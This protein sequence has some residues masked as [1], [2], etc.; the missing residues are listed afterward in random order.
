[1]SDR[2]TIVRRL[3]TLLAACLL[4]GAVSAVAAQADPFGELHQFGEAELKGTEVPEKA[5]GVDAETGDVYAVVESSAGKFTLS[6]FVPGGGTYKAAASVTFQPEAEKYKESEEIGG[7]EVEGV[8]IDSKMHRA[9]V[10]VNEARE[11]ESEVEVSLDPERP[12]AAAIY[13]FSTVASGST[14]VP[15]VGEGGKLVSSIALQPLSNARGIS[16]VEPGGIAVDPT[17]DQIVLAANIDRNLKHEEEERTSVIQRISPTGTL[18]ARYLAPRTEAANPNCG[19][20]GSPVVS[21]TGAVYVLGEG[22][23]ILE[24]PNPSTTKVAPETV[25]VKPVVK[26]KFNFA[27]EFEEE[28]RIGKNTELFEEKLL[29]VEEEHAGSAL[30]ISPEGDLWAYAR[31]KYQL[32]GKAEEFSYGGAVEFNSEFDEIGWTGGQS[33]AT[34]AGKCVVDD[35]KELPAIAAG[36]GG[37]LFALDRSPAN[38]GQGESESPHIIEFGTGGGGCPHGQGTLEASTGGQSLPEGATVPEGE[39]VT[40]TTPLLQA[41]A[42][43]TEWEFEPGVKPIVVDKRE[44]EQTQIEHKFSV[45]GDLTVKETIHTDNLAT[46]TIT[47]ERK[48]QSVIPGKP[49]VVTG[50]AQVA[51]TTVKLKG[52]V[53][54]N[55]TTQGIVECVFEYGTTTKYGGTAPCAQLPGPGLEAKEVTASVSSGLAKHSEYH[56]RVVAKGAVKTE[57]ADKTFTT[58]PAPTVSSGAASAVEQTSAT[59]TGSVDPE[60]ASVSSCELEYGTSTSYGSSI[61]C[62]TSAGSG[63]LAVGESFALSGLSPD[64]TYYF[65]IV[66]ASAGGKGEGSNA[67]FTTAASQTTGGG[68]G[69]GTGGGEVLGEKH[70]APPLLPEP[71][72]SVATT[73][74]TVSASGTVIIKVSCAATAPSCAGTVTLRTVKAVLASAHA[75]KKNKPKAKILTLASASFSIAAGSVEKVTFHLSTTARQVLAK[76]HVLAASVTVAS[77]DAAGTTATTTA[78]VTLRPAKAKKKR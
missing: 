2:T 17:N 54:P 68:G 33:A 31:V 71:K 62:P 61:P 21:K 13:A 30:T 1:M 20:L 27:C 73:S 5:L 57:G 4:I 69:G 45:E 15:A 24:F 49:T 46:P 40:F 16:L 60:G 23:E 75:S 8:A 12:A 74:A 59:I 77:H 38:A 41:N 43:S 47:L 76:L 65:R 58:G 78:V 51:G 72:A 9:Y 3:L 52:T 37:A 55:S 36:A 56:F 22:S 44:E 11:P 48:I 50:S 35:L 14:L 18:G 7:L 66:A 32:A 53:D 25:V 42:L 63:E 6:Q 29:A 70:E 26:D 19:C 34:G 10:L 64:T 67:T 28:C 39:A